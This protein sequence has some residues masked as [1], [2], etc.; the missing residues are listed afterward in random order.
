MQER[1][2]STPCETGM[3]ST[4]APERPAGPPR[5]SPLV[6]LGLVFGLVALVAVSFLAGGNSPATAGG[7]GPPVGP[8]PVVKSTALPG[9]GDTA[10]L[11]A[12]PIVGK[13]APDFTWTGEDGKPVRLSDFR[14]KSILINFWATWCPP[15][16]AEMP[17]IEGYWRDNKEKAVMI[18]AVNVGSEDEATIRAFMK[19]YRL[20]FQALNDTSGQVGSA[21]RVN[22]IPA[23]FFVDTAGIVRDSFVG[24]MSRGVINAGMAKAK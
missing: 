22:G 9:G 6:I 4:E 20:S 23:T 7:D 2:D 19:Q 15:C 8:V 11:P 12:A 21:Y 3:S 5:N 18:L 1:L 14:G 16:K 17:T 10:A 13:Y 24:E